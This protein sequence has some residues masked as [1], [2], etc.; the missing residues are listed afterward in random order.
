MRLAYAKSRL[1]F[2][3]VVEADAALAAKLRDGPRG[4]FYDVVIDATGS[5]AA[6]NDALGYLGH[7]GRLVFVGVSQGDI[8]FDDPEFH[9][10]ETTLIASR[11]AL[12]RDFNRVTAALK[13]GAI[14]AS[15]LQTHSVVGEEM[16]GRLPELIAN[17]DHVLKAVAS[18]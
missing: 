13:S 3:D 1:G 5:I 8:T 15:D 7:G 17:A 2:D 18:F 11:N 16:P 4:E 10:R 14:R 12:P 6:M 9:K